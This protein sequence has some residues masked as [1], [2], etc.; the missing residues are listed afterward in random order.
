MAWSGITPSVCPVKY[1]LLYVIVSEWLI[2]AEQYS[3]SLKSLFK[4]SRSF[5][6]KLIARFVGIPCHGFVV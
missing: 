6:R 4:S 2:E 3:T 5:W 1:S